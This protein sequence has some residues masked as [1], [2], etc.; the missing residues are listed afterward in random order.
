MFDWCFYGPWLASC[1]AVVASVAVC[2]FQFVKRG[3]W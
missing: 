2:V 3:Y 1:A